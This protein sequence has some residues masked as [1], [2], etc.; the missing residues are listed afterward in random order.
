MLNVGQPS[1]LYPAAVGEHDYQLLEQSLRRPR[2]PAL[3]EPPPLLAGR[4]KL[5]RHLGTGALATVYR[6][7]DT[8]GG[9]GGS[10]GDVLAIKLV[11]SSQLMD[12][13]VLLSFE[14]EAGLL[15]S[16]EHPHIVR[17]YRF[18]HHPPW[19][20]VSMELLTGGSLA[21]LARHPLRSR[22]RCLHHIRCL[23]AAL[24]Y[25]HQRGVV[26]GD[27]K[28]EN[29]LLDAGGCV[30]LVDFARLPGVD[31]WTA[32]YASPRRLAGKAPGAA[33]DVYSLAVMA[34]ELLGGG[35]PYRGLPADQ[36]RR[37]DM[38]PQRPP[39]LSRRQWRALAGGLCLE[40]ERRWQWGGE[41]AAALGD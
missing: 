24:A 41:F 18:Y 30:R 39:G 11:R 10:G 4:F 9:Q 17:A 15:A 40:D 12:H 3:I 21:V 8:C 13:R 7:L 20:F 36:A 25:L 32:P 19:Y 23:A 35:H 34:C 29:V 5:L 22:I 37:R 26:H 16:L 6:A 28:P 33:D 2:R 31:A 38:L 14:N 1:L 27:I